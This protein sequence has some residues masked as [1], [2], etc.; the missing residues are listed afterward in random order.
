MKFFYVIDCN[1]KSL[2]KLSFSSLSSELAQWT[3]KLECAKSCR[4]GKLFMHRNVLFSCQLF[5]PSASAIANFFC[6][7]CMHESGTIFITQQLIREWN[8]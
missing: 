1:R 3:K 5:K 6:Y 8:V 2:L 4:N 7:F